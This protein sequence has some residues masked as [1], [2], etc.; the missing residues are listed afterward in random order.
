MWLS[1]CAPFLV[2]HKGFAKGV[3]LGKPLVVKF[4]TYTVI[5]S[6]RRGNPNFID[7]F[8]LLNKSRNDKLYLRNGKSESQKNFMIPSRRNIDY[9]SISNISG[10]P[11]F[12]I[13]RKT[14][15]KSKYNSAP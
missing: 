1:L 4:F 13:V 6:R 8:D 10:K 5:A 7:C 9:K 15:R 14:E 12:Y 11:T 2:A 3:P